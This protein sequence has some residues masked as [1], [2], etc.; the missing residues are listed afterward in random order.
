[1]PAAP[2]EPDTMRLVPAD[3]AE[4]EALLDGWPE[5]GSGLPFFL[6]ADWMR[7]VLTIAPAPRSLHVLAAADR[8]LALLGRQREVRHR[9]L[10]VGQW[11]LNETGDAAFDRIALEYNGFAGLTDDAEATETAFAWLLRHLPSMDEL[12]VR[13]AGAHTAAALGRAAETAGWGV[14]SMNDSPGAALDLATVRA[15]GG[16]LLETLGKNTR[17]AIRRTNRLYAESGPIRVERAGSVTEAWSWFERMAELHVASWEGR[18]ARNAF[19]NPHFR[20]FHRALIERA[21]PAGRIDMLRIHAGDREIGYLYNFAADGWVMAYQAGLT[22]PPDNRWKPGLVCHAAAIA[23]CLERGDRIYDFLA[24]PA[25]YKSSLANCEVPMES[26]VAF[27]P[28]WHLRL[29][30]AARRLKNKR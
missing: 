17:A 3:T 21:L 10:R 16:D 25:R 8:P 7:S 18:T 29:E 19:T 27:A 12:V 9:L 20:P 11:L 22:P 5:A 14:R 26:L 24:G 4:A 23:F 15:A 1:M 28:K 13:N 2:L 6:S 30:D